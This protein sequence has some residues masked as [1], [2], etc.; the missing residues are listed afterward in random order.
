MSCGFSSLELVV[1]FGLV[2]LIGWMWW[3][4]FN[5]D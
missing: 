1:F 4:M 2:G 5:A 3:V